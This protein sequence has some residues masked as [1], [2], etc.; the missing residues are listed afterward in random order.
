MK[1]ETTSFDHNFY[2]HVIHTPNCHSDYVRHEV[3]VYN[4]VNDRHAVYQT[5]L[6]YWGNDYSYP[7]PRLCLS[8]DGGADGVLCLID[9]LTE[10]EMEKMEDSEDLQEFLDSVCLDSWEELR[11]MFYALRENEHSARAYL[12]GLGFSEDVEDYEVDEET[13]EATLKETN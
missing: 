8:F 2:R 1:I 7:S 10:C 3:D 9:S 12:E 11:D 4:M 6:S 13:G 5:G